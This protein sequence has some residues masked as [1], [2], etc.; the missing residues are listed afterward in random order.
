MNEKKTN[1]T[2]KTTNKLKNKT[3]NKTKKPLNKTK[4]LI[5]SPIKQQI[6]NIEISNSSLNSLNELK[7]TVAKYYKEYINKHK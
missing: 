7:T 5:N 1:K 4:K 6:L 2:N 3:K